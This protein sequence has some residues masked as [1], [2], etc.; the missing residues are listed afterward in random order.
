MRARG[1][2]VE[3]VLSDNMVQRQ[4]LASRKDSC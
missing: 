2:C 4:E 1:G 3:D